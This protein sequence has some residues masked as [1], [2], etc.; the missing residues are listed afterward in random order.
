MKLYYTK[1]CL[2]VPVHRQA[3]PGYRNYPTRF[4]KL[5]GIIMQLISMAKARELG[6]KLDTDYEYYPD[7][8]VI[9]LTIGKNEIELPILVIPG[10]NADTIA[11]AVGYGRNES[12]G[13]TVAGVGENV[14][15]L[16]SFNGTTIDLF[17]TG[18]T[19]ENLHRKQK[20]AQTQ[21]HNSYED[22][23]EVVRETTLATFKK[24]PEC[25]SGIER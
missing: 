25:Y 8:P 20:I 18:V 5:P 2:S 14:Y 15:P 10:M 12:I 11:I 22:R 4:Q 13:K 3:I 6:I 17:V 16:A 24:D 19:I 23:V 21:I 1:K 7:K 9:K